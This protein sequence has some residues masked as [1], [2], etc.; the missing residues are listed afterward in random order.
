MNI[1]KRVRKGCVLSPDILSPYTH[2]VM[3]VLTELDGMKIG[4]QNV[5]SIRY[6]ED[7][8]LLAVAEEKPQRLMDELN[9]QCRIDDWKIIK[10]RTEV[11][12][13]TKKKERLAVNL[14]NEGV[15]KNQVEKFKYFGSLVRE[16]EDIMS[17]QDREFQWESPTLVK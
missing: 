1:E 15:A 2:L 5:N 7:K 6:A 11:M 17:K 9:E 4:N 16:D 10:S 12:D 13:V 8:V 3:N 14:N